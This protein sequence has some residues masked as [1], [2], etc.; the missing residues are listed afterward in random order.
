[1]KKTILEVKGID[2]AFPGV[3]ALD[4]V[5]FECNEGEVHA[6][7]GENGAG[8]S[9]LMKI[10]VG[11]YHQDKGTISFK[12]REVNISDPQHA[13][14]LGISIVYQEFDLIPYLDVAQNIFLG[15][16]PR[17]RFGLIDQS[18]M[19]NEASRLLDILGVHLDLREWINNLRVAEQQIVAIAKTLSRSGSLIIM[20]EPTSA[21]SEQETER[22]FNIIGSLKA[23]GMAIIYISHRIEEIF[24]IADR[25]TV[26]RDGKV[27]N[28]TEVEKTSKENLVRMMIG[29]SLSRLFPEKTK[30]SHE[31]VLSVVGLTKKG[32]LENISFT[33]YK[34]EILGMAGLEGSGLTQLAKAL[35]GIESIDKGKIFLNDREVRINTPKKALKA[36]LGLVPENRAVEG[37][38]LSS[39][40]CRNLTLCILDQMRRLGFIRAQEERER[41]GKIVSDLNIRIASLKQEVQ[42]VSGG[43]QQKIVVGK[44]LATM[45]Q[46]IIFDKPTRGIDVGAKVEVHHLMAELA[47]RGKS[48]I[49]IS[50]ELPEV[51][52][53]SNRIIVMDRGRITAEFLAEE[54]TEAKIMAAATGLRSKEKN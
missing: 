54:A 49:M 51:L 47:R 12:G 17:K 26:L 30:S 4:D 20:D 23:Q 27:V 53:M 42:Y 48:I 24:Q 9:T 13:E 25:V 6:L 44:W 19:Y 50:T 5:S 15:R 36:G 41:A 38:V 40:V 28:T 35:V 2:K 33:L 8:K 22:L 39:S 32:V 18:K 29:R 3:Q 10:V 21:L 37:L 16:E 14:Q 46:I 1:M 45:P 31:S 7:V 34:G 43:N 11:V 52:G